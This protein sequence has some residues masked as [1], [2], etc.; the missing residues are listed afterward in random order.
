MSESFETTN[1]PDYP[2]MPLNQFL[3][4]VASD[5]PA[6]GG[7]SVAATAVALAGCLSAMVA[8]FSHK[9]DPDAGKLAGQAEDLR[10]KAEPLIRADAEAYRN[11]LAAYRLPHDTEDR[12]E[13]IH[14]A[15]SEAADVP[16]SIAEAGAEI[17]ELAARLAQK[18]N[19]NL[20]EDAITAILLAEAGVCSA[21]GLVK[22]NAPGE[23]DRPQ[24]AEKLAG[25]TADLRAKAR[26]TE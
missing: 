8:R 13:R 15:L 3:D 11:V 21:A 2:Q 26:G 14:A 10:Q 5:E 19:A 22:T 25:A 7:G 16:L 20:K 17:A 12:E 9:D 23:D 1:V 4:S 6:P 24:R 18:G